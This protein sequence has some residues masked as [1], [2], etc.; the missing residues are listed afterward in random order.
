M[1]I[2]DFGN[3][4]SV[5]TTTFDLF[6]VFGETLT[7]ATATDLDWSGTGNK[8]FTMTGTG[9]Q[10]VASG[11][12]LT[13]LTGGTLTS[14]EANF[15]GLI[16]AH[17]T[18]WNISAASWFDLFIAQD[19][20]GMLGL[21]LSGNDQMK[22]TI[23][24]DILTGLAGRDTVFGN[25]GDDSI[26]GGLG[27]DRL[28]GGPGNDTLTGGLGADSFVFGGVLA[29]SGNIDRIT[30]FAHNIDHILLGHL[31]FLHLGALGPL[32]A[33]NFAHGPATTTAQHV[34]YDALT[35]IVSYDA[36]G[37]GSGAALPFAQIPAGHVLTF[38]DFVVI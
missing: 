9:L 29:A 8:T 30:D 27:N 12:V 36:D 25:S 2:I 3:L 38:G 37:S 28:V 23:G 32:H 10:P 4:T 35:G 20:H 34:L 16:T 22:G 5:Q 1:A 31:T 7:T 13:D 21:V 19:W 17:I 15:N 14:L 11:G 18:N 26:A 24:N 33:A 6:F